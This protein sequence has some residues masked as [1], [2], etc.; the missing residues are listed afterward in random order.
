MKRKALQ[1]L[2][3]CL[4][5]P[6][7]FSFAQDPYGGLDKRS[8]RTAKRYVSWAKEYI[9]VKE[10]H[11][12]AELLREGLTLVPTSRD[13]HYFMGVAYLNSSTED[14]GKALVHL[15]KGRDAED[16]KVMIDYYLGMAFHYQHQMDSALYYYQKY[17]GR[18]S[19]SNAQDEI[20]EV[21]Q[22]INQCQ[23]GSVLMSDSLEVTIYNLGDSINTDRPEIAPVISADESIL[24]FTSRR[25]DS[26]GEEMDPLYDLPYE[27]IYIAEKND[28]GV[29][30]T[31]K[32]IGS[33][34][35][36]D[37]HDAAIGMSP[38]ASKLFIYKSEDSERELSGD[39]YVSNFDKGK[40]S[41]P[42]P[43][44]GIINTP[45]W[46]TH[47]TITADGKAMYFV[48]NRPD[49]MA[50]GE[51]DIYVVRKLPNGKWAVP[52]N[53]GS[54]I[55]TP[56]DE[57]SPFIHPNGNILY[58]SSKGH[59]GMGGFDIFSSEWNE[60]TQEW[61]QAKNIG[62]PINTAYDDIF[63]TVSAD[64]NR[65]YFSS[66]RSD[67]RGGQD[68]YMVNDPYHTA[69]ELIVFRGD[70][71][72]IMTKEPLEA[73]ISVV[74]KSTMK[75]VSEK[76]TNPNNGR[77]T[78][79]LNPG[80]SYAVFITKD[81]YLF[82]S[83]A[84]NVSEQTGFLNVDESFELKRKGDYQSEELSNTFF[85]EYNDL[86]ANSSNELKVL[87]EF[88]KNEDDFVVELVVH[89][90]PEEE[91]APIVAKLETQ[92]KADAIIR[93]LEFF[94][95]KEGD[96][97]GK[98]YGFGQEFPIA[99]NA[100]KLGKLKNSRVEYVLRFKDNYNG[101]LD[102]NMVLNALNREKKKLVAIPVPMNGQEVEIPY[103][104]TFATASN[105][106]DDD[107]KNAIDLI[108][109]MMDKYPSV[110]L[111]V[112]GHTDS[113]GSARY[114]MILG[115]KRADIIASQ[116]V[117]K[118][119]ERDRLRVKSYGEEKPIAPNDTDEGRKKNRR[120]T[121]KVVSGGVEG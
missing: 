76:S 4:F 58:F 59:H 119:I 25:K 9:R 26:M 40:W 95:V 103:A 49:D 66:I 14:K 94:G 16:A 48:S 65:G 34:I 18:L 109:A 2:L 17:Q 61:S 53:L 27:D 64:G 30:Q 57:E 32:N 54:Q 100:T 91:K 108:V 51:R 99:D 80:E 86:T 81:N 68:I 23:Y 35:N 77:F 5:F 83:Y 20:R 113:V 41:V 12:A 106:L 22:L 52:E 74:S 116:I 3:V 73:M 79:L 105:Q 63:Y 56:Y 93:E 39:I 107:T 111:E 104:I 98:G 44:E 28:L 50:Q 45:Y 92:A 29:W 110:T 1:F 85:T 43:L 96:A 67:S 121:F 38:D 78:F 8:Y 19:P 118:G 120:I 7:V 6:T 72:D 46:E 82:K 37:G 69:E 33:K 87:S 88:I 42:Q 89:Q 60:E 102:Y 24:I 70:V 36:T 15:R 71:S 10:Y 11:F 117:Y 115:E 55:N 101:Q 97:I 31:P 47:A 112:G 90:A 84:L 13:L 21:E 114:N 62:Y 75:L